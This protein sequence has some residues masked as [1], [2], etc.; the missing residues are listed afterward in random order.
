MKLSRLE[1]NETIIGRMDSLY[2]TLKRLNKDIDINEYSKIF[3]KN[4]VEPST[5]IYK[6]HLKNV[7]L[8]IEDTK[9]IFIKFEELKVIKRN[10]IYELIE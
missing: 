10:F 1:R 3:I 4:Y 2:Y 6:R 9:K 7:E 5:K 8:T